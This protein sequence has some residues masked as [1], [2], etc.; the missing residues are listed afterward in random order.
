MIAAGY[1]RVSSEQQL[2]GQGLSDQRDK[3]V[4]Y[5]AAHNIEL[6]KI[7]EDVITGT[8]IER[9]ALTE[10]LSDAE[11]GQFN[12]VVVKDLDRLSR[13]LEV[14]LQVERLLTMRNLKVIST[15]HDF[16]GMNAP[17]KK[18]FKN[19]NGAVNEYHK[20]KLV[21]KMSEGK[22]AKFKRGIGPVA[23]RAAY[24]FRYDPDSPRGARKLIKHSQEYPVLEKMR[25][26]RSEGLTLRDIASLLNE[27][28][29]T[30]RYDKPWSY[31]KVHNALNS[32]HANGNISHRGI[33][34]KITSE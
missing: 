31:G 1:T 21:E 11:S 3:I 34:T 29:I 30:A 8:V 32:N 33:V 20:D 9:P 25:Q 4:N 19:I 17:E 27:D 2:D 22:D 7:Y 6:F 10:L 15:K 13:S 18:M 24:G 12:V 16:E 26:M 28:G 14:Q 23:G 5:C